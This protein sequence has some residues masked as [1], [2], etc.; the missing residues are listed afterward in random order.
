MTHNDWTAKPWHLDEH[1]HLTN[2][3]VLRA[4][5]FLGNRDRSAPFFLTVSFIAPH[6]PLQPPAFYLERYLRTGVPDP[7]IGGWAIQ[8]EKMTAGGQGV[9]APDRIRLEG[10]ALRS[11]RAACYGLNNLYM[12]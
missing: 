11:T 2:W 4:L 10:E 5:E 9:V 8:P 1:R 6:P 7:V 3:T 12:W